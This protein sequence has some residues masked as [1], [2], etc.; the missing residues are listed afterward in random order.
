M[1]MTLVSNFRTCE[2]DCCNEVHEGH[3]FCR[4]HYKKFRRYGSPIGPFPAKGY[5]ICKVDY[6]S[7][8]VE[9][10]LYCVKHLRQVQIHGQVTD[11]VRKKKTCKADDCDKQAKALGLCNRHRRWLEKTGDY[12]TPISRQ[13]VGYGTGNDG[14]EYQWVKIEDDPYYPN[15]WIQEHRLVMAHQVGR[16]LEKFENVHHI[17]GEKKDN[18]LG[19]LE[20]WTTS[21]PSGQRVTDKIAWAIELLER[22]APERLK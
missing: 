11:G 21:Q 3:G 15:E 18:R 20:L 17:N 8:R 16:R 19:N 2:V 22:Y 10:H 4:S 6:C 5:Q 9:A 7:Q 14:S 12:N 1:A 13:G